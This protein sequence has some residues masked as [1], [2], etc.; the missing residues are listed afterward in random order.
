MPEPLQA[1]SIATLEKI[2]AAAEIV[3][4]REG[5]AGLTMEG[6]AQEAGISKG[7]VLHH[8]RSK[9]AMIA[10]LAS[11]KLHIL[12]D[13]LERQTALLD[14]TRHKSLGGMIAHAFTTYGPDESFSRAML[15]AAVENSH[16]LEQ[17]RALFADTLDR[18]RAESAAPDS[19]AALLFA[20]IGILVSRTLGFAELEQAQAEKVFQALRTMASS[21]PERVDDPRGLADPSSPRNL[22][23]EAV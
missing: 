13:G 4:T 23:D 21:L 11:R 16:S 15:V 8:F 5:V 2:L 22:P 7:G 3:V 9:E 19:S 10:K 6:V 1:R 12:R 18:V 17:F 14:G 20:V